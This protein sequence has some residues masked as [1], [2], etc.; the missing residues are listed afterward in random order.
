LFDPEVLMTLRIFNTLNR[1]Q[2]TFEPL[3]PGRVGIYVCGVTVYDD[4][5]LGHARGA[6]AFEIIRKYLQFSGYDVTYV[7]NFT[8]VDDKII[9]RSQEEGVP[10]AEIANRYIQAFRED[11]ERLGIPHADIEPRATDHIPSMVDMIE[12][13]IQKGFAYASEGDVYFAV[14][15]FEDYGRL[16]RKNLDELESGARVEVSEHKR[17]PLDFALWKS[18]KPGEP[19]WDSPWGKGRPGWHIEC[20]AMSHS[21][22]SE[23]FDIHGGGE[24][25]IF[26]HHE[27]ERAQSCAFSGGVFA[28][29]WLHN[30]LVRI[31][32]E[33][34]SKSTGNFFTVKA[35]LQ[36]FRPE[37][38]RYFLASS[39]YRSA[40]EYS[41][42]AV[43]TAGRG[44]DRLYNACLRAAEA[45]PSKD[46]GGDRAASA[47]LR[48]EILDQTVK[49]F[50]A[51]FTAG[52]DDDFNTPR[53]IGA[54]FT[55]AHEIHSVIDRAD[56]SQ[57]LAPE[58]SLKNAV[59]SLQERARTLTFL[60]HEPQEWFQQTYTPEQ[61]AAEGD[62]VSLDEETI[63]RMIRERNEARAR[64]D[65]AE[66]DR[67]RDELKAKSI[68]LEDGSAGTSWKRVQV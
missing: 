52:M 2:E 56:S 34:M 44:L 55:L 22:L 68:V 67:I 20:S 21:L 17:D 23:N 65:F 47:P 24:D 13:L 51:E 16:S 3:Q 38:V 1:R 27:N 41:E 26:P 12:G 39:H 63:E 5:H 28:R 32:K 11:M 35:I 10:A 19:S 31:H 46:G 60:T 54:M 43:V 53:A 62:G 30:G 36:T 57:G 40:V 6:L 61:A 42:E 25:L 4:I 9:N 49:S 29:Y 59:Q 18:A 50:E 64:K 66:A 58:D 45:C 37:V 15:T 8:D 48:D 7:R 33:K 14:R